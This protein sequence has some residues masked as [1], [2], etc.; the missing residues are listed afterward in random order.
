M[1]TNGGVGGNGRNRTNGKSINVHE[2]MHL[3]NIYPIS[4]M[5]LLLTFFIP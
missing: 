3:Y 4:K 5:T 1:G 2:F